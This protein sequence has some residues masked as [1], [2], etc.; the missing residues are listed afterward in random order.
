[1]VDFDSTW[2]LAHVA[3]GTAEE[4]VGTES[5]VG[6][7]VMVEIVDGLTKQAVGGDGDIVAVEAVGLFEYGQHG[8]PTSAAVTSSDGEQSP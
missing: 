2:R 1:M 5:L 6:G 8:G 4:V 7:A 3:V